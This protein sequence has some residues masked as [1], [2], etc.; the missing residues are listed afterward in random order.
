MKVVEEER[1][2]GTDGDQEEMTKSEDTF[3]SVEFD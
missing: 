2:K 3:G 1:K